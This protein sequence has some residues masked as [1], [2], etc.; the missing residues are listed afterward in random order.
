MS[1]KK[2]CICQ[3]TTSKM[4]REEQCDDYKMGGEFTNTADN[5]DLFQKDCYR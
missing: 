4:L 2:K 5:P 1:I 3:Y